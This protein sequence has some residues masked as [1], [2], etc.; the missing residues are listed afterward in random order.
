MPV[1]EDVASP[2]KNYINLCDPRLWN[3]SYQQRIFSKQEFMN[4]R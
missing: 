1:T 2:Q 3:S 4:F